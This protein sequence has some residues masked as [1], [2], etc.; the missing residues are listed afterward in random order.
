[1]PRWEYHSALLE[2]VS[3][4]SIHKGWRLK[5]INEQ[6]QSHWQKTRLYAS[7]AD[8]CTQ[9][10]QQGWELVSAVY[11]GHHGSEVGLYFKRPL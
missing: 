1:M 7:V 6:E 8:F 4:W 5:E 2:V 9:M 3:S 11:S 10:G